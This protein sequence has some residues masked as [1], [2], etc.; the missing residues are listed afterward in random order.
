MQGD[1]GRLLPETVTLGSIRILEKNISEPVMQS[2]VAQSSVCFVAQ[3]IDM[4]SRKPNQTI[5]I[6]SRSL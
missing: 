1:A 6:L 2:D 4:L 3:S 5:R